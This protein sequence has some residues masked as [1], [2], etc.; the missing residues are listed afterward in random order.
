MKVRVCIHLGK[1]WTRP[2]KWSEPQLFPVNKILKS[3]NPAPQWYVLRESGGS[4]EDTV[5]R[6]PSCMREWGAAIDAQPEV[7][8]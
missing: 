2:W 1:E 4:F 7:E 5:G 6:L 3:P 8:H